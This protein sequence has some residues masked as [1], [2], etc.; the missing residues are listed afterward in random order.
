MYGHK[1]FLIVQKEWPTAI[2]VV[3][4]LQRRFPQRN[5]TVPASVTCADHFLTNED[6]TLPKTKS[7]NES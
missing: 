6:R 1:A 2:G 4:N 7:M 5:M 3:N